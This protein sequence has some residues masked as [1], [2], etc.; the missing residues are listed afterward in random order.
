MGSDSIFDLFNL[1]FKKI[2]NILGVTHLD[3]VFCYFPYNRKT[4]P[5]YENKLW[6]GRVCTHFCISRL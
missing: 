4:A 5:W 1:K 2:N 3:P 6:L